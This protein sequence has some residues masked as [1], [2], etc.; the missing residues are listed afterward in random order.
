MMDRCAACDSGSW[1]ITERCGGY[2]LALCQECGLT[3]TRNP[4]YSSQRYL[5]AYR[6]ASGQTLVPEEDAY[7]YSMPVMRL[8]LESLAFLPPAP[9]LP[10]AHDC[11]IEQNPDS[12]R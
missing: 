2:E 12:F 6:K 9:R 5:A 8:E 11:W 3:F 1:S 7:K 10:P 4:D